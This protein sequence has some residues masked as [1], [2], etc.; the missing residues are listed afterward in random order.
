MNYIA[1]W[2]ENKKHKKTGLDK[3]GSFEKLEYL[4]T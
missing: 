3:T 2:L 4:K 1:N